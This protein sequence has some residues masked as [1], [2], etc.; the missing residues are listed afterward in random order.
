[1]AILPF[2]SR[3]VEALGHK[4]DVLVGIS[5]SGN[6]PNIVL[7]LEQARTMGI[8]TVALT[9]LAGGKSALVA[10]HVVCV[11]STDTPRIQEAHILLGHMLC[12]W[13]ELDWIG[14]ETEDLRIS[15]SRRDDR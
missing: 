10:D 9:G 3:Q 2:F 8:T 15:E 11:P 4:G 1:M 5:T 6:S 14:S 7:A 12:D 13:L